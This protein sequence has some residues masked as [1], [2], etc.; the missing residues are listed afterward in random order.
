MSKTYRTPEQNKFRKRKSPVINNVKYIRDAGC[1]SC[2]LWDQIPRICDPSLQ[3]NHKGVC[4]LQDPSQTTSQA[5]NHGEKQPMNPSCLP[6]A[7]KY[8]SL[9]APGDREARTSPG[10]LGH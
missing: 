3:E 7:P 4:G 2:L 8:H 10:T 9:G 5:D 6:S 1:V